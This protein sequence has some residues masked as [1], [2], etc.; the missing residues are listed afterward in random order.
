ME[1]FGCIGL[2]FGGTESAG[3]GSQLTD[4]APLPSRNEGDKKN[5][6]RVHLIKPWGRVVELA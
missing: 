3:G 1:A 6:T 2:W 5:I 4:P